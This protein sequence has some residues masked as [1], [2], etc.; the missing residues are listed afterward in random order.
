MIIHWSCSRSPRQRSS[1]KDRITPRGYPSVWLDWLSNRK[2]ESFDAFLTRALKSDEDII[3]EGTSFGWVIESRGQWGRI[4]DIR[5]NVG[6][7]QKDWAVVKSYDLPHD[8]CIAVRGHRGWSRD[9]EAAARYALAVT[10][11]I[12][13][14][15]IPIYEPLRMAVLELQAEVEAEVE[16]EA[17]IEV[18]E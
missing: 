10:F 9:P 7:V 18:E 3:Q 11:E 6:T 1:G 16:A 8:L 2:G 4:P 13:G 12:V 14:Q 17:T 15:E 5:R